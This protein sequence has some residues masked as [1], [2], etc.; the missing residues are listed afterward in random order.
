MQQ[1]SKNN[2]AHRALQ[3]EQDLALFR[4]HE[5]TWSW[6]RL[7]V[8]LGGSILAATLFRIHWAIGAAAATATLATFVQTVIHHTE[9]KDKGDAAQ[10][11]LTVIQ[12]SRHNA[13]VAQTPVR[14]SARPQPPDND[15]GLPSMLDAGAVW[16]LTDQELEDLDLYSHPVGLFGLL[17]RTSTDQGARRLS[18]MLESPCLDPDVITQ[19]QHTIKWL[20][21]HTDQRLAL[22]ASALPLR[23]RSQ[24]L[25]HL[26]E[27]VHTMPS[28]WH[29]PAFPA[30]RLWSCVSGLG[31]SYGMGLF[32]TGQF[33]GLTLAAGMLAVNG[34]LWGAFGKSL[35]RVRTQIAPLI[36]LAPALRCLLAH[37]QCAASTLPDEMQLAA[38]KTSFQGVLKHC[39]INALCEWLDWAGLGAVVRSQFNLIFFYDLHVSEAVLKRF[40]PHRTTLRNGLRALADLEALNSLACFS[41]EQPMTCVPT[42]VT[43]TALTLHQA[44]HPLIPS[45]SSTP[46]DI[47]LTADQRTWLITGPNAAG[48]STYLRMVGINLLLAQIGSAVTARAMTFRPLR[49]ITDVRIRDDLA[50]HESYFMSEVRRLRRIVVDTN[51][52][53]PLFCL[54]DEPFRG[55]NSPERTAAGVALLEHLLASQH[56]VLLATHEERLAQTALHSDAAQNHHFQET[57]TS[58]G[59]TFEYQ[60]HPGPA[61]T[62]TAIRILEQEHYPLALV[63]RARALMQDR[64]QNP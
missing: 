16:Q 2:L 19:R 29:R 38:F 13:P 23:K 47:D 39:R 37:A 54:I 31:F 42:C 55:T 11:F 4:Q 15:M 63:K 30:I 57:L 14:S 5:A 10:Q 21:D 33:A 18:E 53:I 56:L 58:A 45:E 22:M 60:L 46:N 43:T 7:G 40:E 12:E 26:I 51:S 28:N 17:N 6:L 1:S 61:S 20:T 48:K 24:C 32:I 49:L 59:I 36:P 3:N 64:S 52:E 50:K 41:A 62:R 9:W 44:H 25:D 27:Q 34:L 8:F 35:T